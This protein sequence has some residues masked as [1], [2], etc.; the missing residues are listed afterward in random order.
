M[1]KAV[2]LNAIF[3]AYGNDD[4]TESEDGQVVFTL[5]EGLHELDYGIDLRELCTKLKSM[6]NLKNSVHIL[7]SKARTDIRLFELQYNKELKIIVDALP[8]DYELNN[9]KRTKEMTF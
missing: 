9:L 7:M 4:R 6:F 3:Q 1:N 5:N 2:R 8:I